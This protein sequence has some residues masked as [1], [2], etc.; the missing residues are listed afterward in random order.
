[1]VKTAGHCDVCNK[2]VKD[3]W[4]HNKG[5]KH[6]KMLEKAKSPEVPPEDTTGMGEGV[7][8]VEGPTTPSEVTQT[9][10]EEPQNKT[11]A[12]IQIID[13]NTGKPEKSTV[14]N[15]LEVAFS[16]QF[17]PI[18]T[19][20]LGAIVSKLAPHNEE[21]VGPGQFIAE[22]GMTYDRI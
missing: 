19:A 22:D 2:D 8:I 10:T 12:G 3:L 6:L 16:E 1:M 18:T 17:A 14:D 5:K 13:G 4:Q 15:I 7:S 11:I 20:L 9:P 21:Q